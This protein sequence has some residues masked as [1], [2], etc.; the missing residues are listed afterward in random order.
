MR[1][2]R[3]LAAAGVL[4]PLVGGCTATFTPSPRPAVVTP[5]NIVKKQEYIHGTKM[6]LKNFQTAA[7]DL[8]SRRKPV[9]RRELTEEVERY[10][11]MQVEPIVN[12]FEAGNNL[13]T[14]LEI[15]KLQLLCALVYLELAEYR[16]ARQMLGEMTRRYGD[17]PGFLNAAIDRNDIGFGNLE[18]GMRALK[19]RLS[20][21]SPS[22]L[23]PLP[24]RP[25]VPLS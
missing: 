10:I 12:D 16:E 5:M 11:E 13:E 22:L 4:L 19:E 21:E 23:A 18:D 15:G 7:I 20:R 2:V 17:N 14:R 8:G 1:I 24:P 9:A 6:T 3:I 25:P